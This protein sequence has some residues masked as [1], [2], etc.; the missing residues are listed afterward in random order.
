MSLENDSYFDSHKDCLI[1]FM[2]LISL[3]GMSMSKGLEKAI[4]TQEKDE[5]IIQEISDK[6]N[7]HNI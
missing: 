2:R 3:R 1:N 5:E 6:T 4:E 7:F